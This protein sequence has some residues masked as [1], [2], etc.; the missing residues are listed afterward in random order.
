MNKLILTAVITVAIAA[1]A[2]RVGRAQT[3]AAANYPDF[4]GK[5]AVDIQASSPG[6]LL[7]GEPFLVTR[8]TTPQPSFTNA[9]TARQDSGTLRVQRETRSQGVTISLT[10]SYYRLDG[11]ETTNIEGAMT[12]TASTATWQY[13][14]LLIVTRMADP[15]ALPHKKLGRI[16]SLDANGRLVIDTMVGGDPMYLTVYRRAAQ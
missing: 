16:M 9:F 3:Q 11:S 7:D 12:K 8:P 1:G 15:E 5:W 4:S 6:L 10:V 2:G 13:G 14:A